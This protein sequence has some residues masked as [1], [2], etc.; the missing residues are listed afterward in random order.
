MTTKQKLIATA[1]MV[2]TVFL[3]MLPELLAGLQPARTSLALALRGVYW[4]ALFGGLIAIWRRLADV[5]LRRG[6]L[7]LLVFYPYLVWFVNIIDTHYLGRIVPIVYFSYIPLGA[8]VFAR[9]SHALHIENTH[10]DPVVV[11]RSRWRAIAYLAWIVVCTATVLTTFFNERSQLEKSSE[12]FIRQSLPVV[13]TAWSVDELMTRASE[14]YVR[15]TDKARLGAMFD[16]ASSRL[17]PF[18]LYTDVT[19]MA[20]LD[21]G[22]SRRHRPATVD[23][24]A[25]AVFEKGDARIAI[26][27]TK[28]ADDYWRVAAL[29]VDVQPWK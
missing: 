26:R 25:A 19:R 5:A 29:R 6:F 1:A 27:L 28:W 10:P 7:F 21:I 12:D 9:L 24:V 15:D 3:V 20:P 2:V 14:E 16:G 18:A 22:S 8:F 17:G 11:R 23:Y 4:L 13:L